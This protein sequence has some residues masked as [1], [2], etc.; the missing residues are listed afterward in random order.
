MQSQVSGSGGVIAR[1]DAIDQMVA[2]G[3]LK[4]VDAR[5]IEEF[6]AGAELRVVFFA[7]LP[8]RSS[9]A[10]DVAVALRELM[11]EFAVPAAVVA[12]GDESALQSDYRVVVLPSLVLVVEGQVLEVVPGVRDWQD[13]RR[14]F[15]RYLGQPIQI[16][17]TR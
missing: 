12:E 9:E 14:A 6:C 10:Q 5:S 11:R 16:G 1:F 4:T 8:K 2:A 7:G 3:Q 17:A 15:E 13:Y